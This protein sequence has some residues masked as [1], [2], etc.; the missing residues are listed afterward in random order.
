MPQGERVCPIEV[1]TAAS[2]AVE[3]IG[4]FATLYAS[5]R[6]DGTDVRT[7][8]RESLYS[9]REALQSAHDTIFDAEIPHRDQEPQTSDSQRTTA[10]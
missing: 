4:E 9:I 7:I 2:R 6:A 8:G 10:D 1:R 3:A 5:A